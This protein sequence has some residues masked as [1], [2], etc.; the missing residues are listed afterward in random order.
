MRVA[1]ATIAGA[2]LTLILPGL[3]RAQA[4]RDFENSWFWGVSAGT[5]AYGA[6]SATTAGGNLSAAPTVGAEWLITRTHGGLYVSVSQAFFS[7]QTAIANGPTAADSGFRTVDLKNMY[8]FDLAIMAF[9]GGNLFFHPYVGGGMTLNDIGSATPEG[10][11]T[12]QGQIDFANPSIE[13]IKAA[14][15]PLLVAGVQWRFQRTSAF[16]Q[17]KLNSTN[18]D[19]LLYSGNAATFSLQVGARYNVGSSISDDK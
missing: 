14:F 15:S 18:K 7:Q 12:N 9:P 17:V 16:A 6:P 2:C 4:S 3:A 19:F 13:S 8:N 11:F 10:P 1:R 5:L